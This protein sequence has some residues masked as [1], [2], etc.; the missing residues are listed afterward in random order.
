MTDDVRDLA[1]PVNAAMKNVIQARDDRAKQLKT[2]RDK[3]E[4]SSA[5]AAKR[6]EEKNQVNA[7][8]DGKGL[9][10]VGTNPTGMYELC[11][12]HLSAWALDCYAEAVAMVTHKGA[13]ADSG[14]PTNPDSAYQQGT[15]LVGPG[16]RRH[17]SSR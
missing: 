17:R 15:T 7:L 12:E 9:A 6:A 11:G 13:S 2:A 14:K 4:H 8:I 3:V 10:G 16:L 1:R 5:D